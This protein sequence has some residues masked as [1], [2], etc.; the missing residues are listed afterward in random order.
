LTKSR[1]TALLA[2]RGYLRAGL[3][4]SPLVATVWP[5]DTNF[6]L[7]DSPAADEF[8]R[9]AMRG[10]TIVRDLRAHP[11][12]AQSLRVTVGARAD[13]DALLNSVAAS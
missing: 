1:I 7:I 12:L 5:S 4:A 10:G 2:E 11:A 3:A 8:L 13:N 6:L 9:A